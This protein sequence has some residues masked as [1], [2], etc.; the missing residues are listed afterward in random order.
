MSDY[1]TKDTLNRDFRSID[2]VDII[3][4]LALFMGS[5]VMSTAAVI[6]FFGYDFAT[7]VYTAGQATEVSIAM[8]LPALGLIIGVATNETSR[9]DVEKMSD[10]EKSAIGIVV[11]GLLAFALSPDIASLVTDYT[12]GQVIYMTAHVGSGLIIAS[13]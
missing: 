3:A 11:V 12:I 4:I 8:I 2:T 13:E 1:L 7:V 5:A 9:E 10:G 6:Q